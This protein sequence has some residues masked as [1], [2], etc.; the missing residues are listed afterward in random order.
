LAVSKAFVEEGATVVM[1]SIEPSEERDRAVEETAVRPGASTAVLC[2]VSDPQQVD[3][4][5]AGVLDKYGRIDILVNNAGLA[6]WADFFTISTEDWQRTLDVNY[7]G[8]FLCSR[9]VARAM[10][11]RGIRGRIITTSSLGVFVGD[12]KQF[13]YCATK[14]A[15]HNLMQSLA[16]I[17]GPCGISCNSIAP[18]AILTDMNR[19]F[20][21]Y[22]ANRG[23]VSKRTVV[24]RIGEPADVAG[25]YVYFAS[26]DS[27]FTTVHQDRRRNSYPPV[28]RSADL[29]GR[30]Q[31]ALCLPSVSNA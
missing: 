30:Y 8:V 6:G 22:P 10:I 24:G 31:R 12:V 19:D 20:Y 18:T 17:L 26:D 16:V 25:A 23:A 5:V 7:K 11:D 1:A 29:M 14:A 28:A 15:A 3:G 13:H 9:A 4:M 2:D 21:A 27:G